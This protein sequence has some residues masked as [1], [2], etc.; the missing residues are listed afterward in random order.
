[1]RNKGKLGI[2]A[3]LLKMRGVEV[4]EVKVMGQVEVEV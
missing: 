1:V 4:E 2:I 3:L